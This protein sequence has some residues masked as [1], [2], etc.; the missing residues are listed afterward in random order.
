MD[1]TA[2]SESGRI[3][4]LLDDVRELSP[5]PAWERVEELVKRLLA[6]QGEGLARLLSHARASGADSGLDGRPVPWR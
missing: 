5:A 2:L 1:E 6:M 4:Q 3:Q